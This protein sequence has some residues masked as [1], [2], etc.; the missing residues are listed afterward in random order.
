[1][2][3]RTHAQNVAHLCG[4]ITTLIGAFRNEVDDAKAAPASKLAELA[5]VGRDIVD[6]I[7][8]ALEDIKSVQTRLVQVMVPEAF[9]REN[10]KS[11]TTQAGHRVTVSMLVRA[12]IKDQKLAFDWLK[13][14]GYG[15]IIKP[16]V[17]ASTLS[18]VAREILENDG[19]DPDAP[20][21]LPEDIFNVTTIPSTSIVRSKKS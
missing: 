6:A 20:T 1:M 15:D 13:E 9:D 8:A 19:S 3:E 2:T 5:L 12:S 14:N 17:N 18:G 4:D 10:I 21:D 11:F 16:T 7:D